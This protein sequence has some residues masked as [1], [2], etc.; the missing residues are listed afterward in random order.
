MSE[1]QELKPPNELYIYLYIWIWI[2]IWW[3]GGKHIWSIKYGYFMLI[4]PHRTYAHGKYWRNC[5]ITFF[6]L[7]EISLETFADELCHTIIPVHLVFMRI[8]YAS[9]FSL[10]CHKIF[11]L[12]WRAFEPT[13]ASWVCILNSLNQP[14][15]ISFEKK[16]QFVRWFISNFDWFWNSTRTHTLFRGLS[17]FDEMLNLSYHSIRYSMRCAV[18][19]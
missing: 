4:A 17:R 8:R 7:F 15:F 10:K 2:W 6:R 18:L 13:Q 3:C 9:F 16:E 11:L 12:I 5:E 19:R 1:E 14:Y